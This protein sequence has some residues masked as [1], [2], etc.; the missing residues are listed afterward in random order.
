MNA[1]QQ[2]TYTQFIR[3]QQNLAQQLQK[4]FQEQAS[5]KPPVVASSHANFQILQQ[6]SVVRGP[7]FNQAPMRPIPEAED[8]NKNF[9]LKQMPDNKIEQEKP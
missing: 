8:E 3:N 6:H 9:M 1:Q 2:N 4:T 5:E 7:N